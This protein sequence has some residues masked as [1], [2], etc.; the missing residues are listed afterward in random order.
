MTK[1]FLAATVLALATPAAAAPMWI[2]RQ[3]VPKARLIDPAFAESAAEASAIVDHAPWTGFLEIYVVAGADGINRVRYAAVNA[4]DR[5]ALGAYVAS[6]E[7]TDVGSL[8]TGEQ[9]A[10][11]INLYNAATVR[12]ILDNPGVVSI[13]DIEKPWDQKIATVEGRALSLNEIEHGIVRPVFNDPRTHYALNCAS[14]GCP[15]LLRQ[16]Y[17]GKAIDGQLDMAARAFV[18]HPRGVTV[19]NGRVTASKIYGWF[20]GDFGADDAGVLD[21]IRGYAA[22]DLAAALHGAKKIDDYSYDWSLNAAP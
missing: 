16:A 4:D 10:F 9:R 6:L 19:E 13:R 1:L 20:A 5:A 3:A 7:A 17:Q 18:N 11:W 22:A 14:I 12:L 21:H 2:E 15:G 8:A